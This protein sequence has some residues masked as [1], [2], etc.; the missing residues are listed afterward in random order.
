M[1]KVYGSLMPLRILEEIRFWKMQEKEH[2]VVIRELAPELEEQYVKLL[3]EWEIVFAKMESTAQQWIESIIR[4]QNHSYPV[5][6][7]EQFVN[8][9]IA[10][11]QQFI[12]QLYQIMDQSEVIKNNQTIIT[13]MMH[14]IRE[15][16]YFLGVLNA[17]LLTPN[18][19]QMENVNEEARVS[20]N[21][22]DDD[23]EMTEQ[24]IPIG[25]HTLPPLPYPYNALEPYIDEETMK[26]HHDKHHLAYVNGLNNAELQ[27]EKARQSDDFSL[28]KHW[29]RELAFNGAGH[30][31]HTIFWNIMSPDGGGDASGAIGAQIIKDFGSYDEFKKQFSAAANNVEGGGWAILVW[32]PRSHR[33][34]ILQA[35]KHQN[36]SQWDVIPLLV[37]DVWEHAYYL[38]YMNNRPD[39]V[40]AWWNVVNWEHVNERFAH[41]R[42]LKWA[43]Y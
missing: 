32:S 30:Y 38:K 25:K 3:Q 35:E 27:L 18:E 28:I 43:A 7:M 16:D 19:P 21:S 14:I 8:S 31:L 5:K 11:S 1:L 26:I 9:S 6:Q 41:A 2:T 12:K 17:Y 36:L 29:E 22:L 39:Y 40:E 15:S 20:S 24:S 13:V 34:E 37:L 4:S 10:Q 23:T 33:L 42:R